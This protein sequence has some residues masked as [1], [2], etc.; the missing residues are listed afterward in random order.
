MRAANNLYEENI[1][2]SFADEEND[3]IEDLGLNEEH[4]KK[5][6][7]QYDDGKIDYDA[8]RKFM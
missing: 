3:C 6:K 8:L 5:M 7:L 4:M 2:V 1:S